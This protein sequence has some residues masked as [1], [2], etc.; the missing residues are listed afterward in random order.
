MFFFPPSSKSDNWREGGT[1]GESVGASL[2]RRAGFE[3]WKR[4]NSYKVS[5]V[6]LDGYPGSRSG[7]S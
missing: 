3:K 1:V 7:R 2:D 5:E 4:Q 6:K